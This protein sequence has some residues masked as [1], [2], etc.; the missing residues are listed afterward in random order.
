MLDQASPPARTL[1]RLVDSRVRAPHG[2][3]PAFARQVESRVA[4]LAALI[5]QSGEA[6]VGDRV[7][8][9]LGNVRR[10]DSD[11]VHA[12]VYGASVAL[13]AGNRPV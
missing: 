11:L 7:R 1:D 5:Q 6:V 8:V 13:R 9:F 3:D 2:S 12:A 10:S 4:Q